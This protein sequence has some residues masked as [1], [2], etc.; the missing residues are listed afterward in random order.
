M[1]LHRQFQV[2]DFRDCFG[3]GQNRIFNY[4][5]EFIRLDKAESHRP[6]IELKYTNVRSFF[7]IF[8]LNYTQWYQIWHL[9]FFI[10]RF[11]SD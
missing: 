9:I 5:C 1:L 8:N 7:K 2:S 11:Y 4:I 3:P 6:I 10:S